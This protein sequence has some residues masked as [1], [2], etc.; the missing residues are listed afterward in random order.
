MMS[1]TRFFRHG[2]VD[3]G[4]PRLFKDAFKDVDARNKP[5]HDYFFAGD[6]DRQ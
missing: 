5:G 6:F 2:R 1:A 3:P 4:H